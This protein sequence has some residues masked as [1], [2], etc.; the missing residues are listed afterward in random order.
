MNQFPKPSQCIVAGMLR[1][2]QAGGTDQLSLKSEQ[3]RGCGAASAGLE[4]GE[5]S[6]A[7][8]R[9]LWCGLG[10]TGNLSWQQ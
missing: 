8:T 10:G 9:C 5:Q 6:W 7:K 2:A 3:E 1:P 4:N